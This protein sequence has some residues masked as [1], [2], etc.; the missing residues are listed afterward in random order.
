MD[1]IEIKYNDTAEIK[2][3][4]RKL[5][6][7]RLQN[8]RLLYY[9]HCNKDFCKRKIAALQSKVN[10]M[11]NTIK[12]LQKENINLKRIEDENVSD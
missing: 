12:D 4:F 8:K 9:L 10:I 6:I 7:L 3:L 5:D 11:E 2:I 1:N